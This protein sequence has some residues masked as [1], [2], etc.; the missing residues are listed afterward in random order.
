MDNKRNA[1]TDIMGSLTEKELAEI[2]EIAKKE[3]GTETFPLDILCS[4]SIAT[5][6]RSAAQKDRDCLQLLFS[7]FCLTL[8]HSAVDTDGP[9]FNLRCM[10]ALA[11]LKGDIT[12]SNRSMEEAECT[13]DGG[14]NNEDTDK[15]TFH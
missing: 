8:I 3:M 11:I 6:W 4:T 2:Y 14:N 15:K 1:I 5:W 13:P 7:R 10:V 12:V 9:D